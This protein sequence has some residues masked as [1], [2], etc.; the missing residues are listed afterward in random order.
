MK[1]ITK[2]SMMALGLMMGLYSLNANAAQ[3]GG[4]SNPKVDQSFSFYF[5]GA[6]QVNWFKVSNHFS[7][8]RFKMGNQNETAYFDANGELLLSSRFLP[9]TDL[10]LEIAQH[11]KN[12]F[13]SLQVKY[14]SEFSSH[15]MTDYLVSLEGANSWKTVRV[16]SDHSIQII[17]HFNKS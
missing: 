16:G 1:K 5:S 12:K 8:A 7:E 13:P 10:P 6:A 2:I 4:P 11:L 15:G 17:S 3:L 14:V 9:A